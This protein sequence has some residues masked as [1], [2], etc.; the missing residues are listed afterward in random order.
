MFKTNRW[1]EEE[2]IEEKREQIEGK[3]RGGGKRKHNNFEGCLK[4]NMKSRESSVKSLCWRENCQGWLCV[5]CVIRV[6]LKD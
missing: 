3:A 1:N 6:D 2:G 5:K 4:K